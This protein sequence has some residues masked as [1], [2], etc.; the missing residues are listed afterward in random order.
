MPGTIIQYLYYEFLSLFNWWQE[1]DEPRWM[2]NRRRAYGDIL[3]ISG[4]TFRYKIVA[5]DWG[6]GWEKTKCY[7][8]YRKHILQEKAGL[9]HK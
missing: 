4:R 7:R 1:C 6:Q 3:Y 8:K 5:T 9:I 2:T